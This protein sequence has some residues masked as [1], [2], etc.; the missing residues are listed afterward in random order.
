[1]TLV[2]SDLLP[3]TISPSTAPP[4]GVSPL[5]SSTS[6]LLSSWILAS[7]SFTLLAHSR[8]A[9]RWLSARP[10][11]SSGTSI[12][13]PIHFNFSMNLFAMLSFAAGTLRCSAVHVHANIVARH[14]HRISTVPRSPGAVFQLMRFT[15]VKFV[16]G[17]GG[18]NIAVE[19]ARIATIGEQQWGK[20]CEIRRAYVGWQTQ[21]VAGE[22]FCAI[23]EDTC[24]NLPS[25]PQS[26]S[27]EEKEGHNK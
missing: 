9:S 17:P 1:M 10:A 24:D 12:V 26:Y 23:E 14:V 3:G 11:R 5:P 19:A 16:G 18:P 21:V 6:F 27:D 4:L 7:H 13:Y 22:A 15:F 2:Q 8:A 25:P 20:S